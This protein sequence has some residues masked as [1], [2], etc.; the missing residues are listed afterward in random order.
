[1]PGIAAVMPVACYFPTPFNTFCELEY[2]GNPRQ[3]LYWGPWAVDWKD[4]P[5]DP[6]AATPAGIES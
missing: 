2:C 5:W 6:P 4:G 1:M 3:N